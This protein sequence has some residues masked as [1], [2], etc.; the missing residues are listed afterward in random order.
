ME[1]KKPAEILSGV[2]PVLFSSACLLSK[3][4]AAEARR[5]LDVAAEMLLQAATGIDTCTAI[6][7]NTTPQGLGVFEWL[8]TRPSGLTEGFGRLVEFRSRL[9]LLEM[10]ECPSRQVLA[11][12]LEMATNLT[13]ALGGAVRDSRGSR[14]K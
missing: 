10:A 14:L 1:G 9:A 6:E 7:R 2:P 13:A 11:V 5:L 12:L 4:K 3:G 8:G